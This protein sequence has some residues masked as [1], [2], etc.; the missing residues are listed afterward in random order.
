MYTT[1]SRFAVKSH[2][3]ARAESPVGAHAWSLVSVP[4]ETSTGSWKRI[5]PFKTRLRPASNHPAGELI[6]ENDV[7]LAFTLQRHS[8]ESALTRT[9]SVTRRA[10]RMGSH[11]SSVV[12]SVTEQL[13]NW[14]TAELRALDSVSNNKVKDEAWLYGM[15]ELLQRLEDACEHR[16]GG[17]MTILVCAFVHD[18]WAQFGHI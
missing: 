18:F 9:V 14:L 17:Q 11:R 1:F 2:V 6:Q 8:L 16:A 5:Q 10:M 15:L 12:P 13:D 3:S 7:D 4:E